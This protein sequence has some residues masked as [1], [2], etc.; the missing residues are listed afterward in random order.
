MCIAS[1]AFDKLKRQEAHRMSLRFLLACDTMPSNPWERERLPAIREALSGWP[2]DI[3]DLF[4]FHSVEKAHHIHRTKS[5][6][7]FF[8][9]RNLHEL[10]RNFYR[11]VSSFGCDI[12]ML[13][14][15]DCYS[16]F[17][18][19][20]TVDQFRKDGIYVVGILGDDEFMFH[21]NRLHVPMFN[22]TVAYV[23]HCVDLYNELVPNS[24]T[25]FPNSCLFPEKDFEKLQVHEDEKTFD[26]VL[27]GA[28]FGNRPDLIRA[29]IRTGVKVALFGSPKWKAYADLEPYYHGFLDSDQIDNTIRKSK[30]VL[31]LLEDHLTGALHMNT[32]VWEAVRMGQMPVA[33]YYPPLIEDYGFTEDED[34]VMYHSEEDLVRKVIHYLA[35]PDD[36]R[37]VAANLFRNT[38]KRFDYRRMYS[39]LFRIIAADCLSAG[40]A[41]RIAADAAEPVITIIDATGGQRTYPGFRVLPVPQ[42]KQGLKSLRARLMNRVSTPYVLFTTGGCR[43]SPYLNTIAALFPDEFLGGKAAFLAAHSRFSDRDRSTADI[44]QIVWERDAFGKYLETPYRTAV[45]AQVDVLK[46]SFANLRLC[47]SEHSRQLTMEEHHESH[48]AN[49]GPGKRIDAHEEERLSDSGKA[50]VVVGLDCGKEHQFHRRSVCVDGRRG[51]G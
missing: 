11:K 7:V 37:R 2:H 14:T 17:L 10:N 22:K 40:R 26:V 16:W 32:K 3:I 19:P 31:A 43:Y 35:D 41:G 23:R 50:H 20:D 27:F 49:D 8:S 38:R 13:G 45:P 9:G 29:L 33:T 4:A 47:T 51:D 39:N 42:G 21:R 36:R 46:Y 5:H 18:F 48:C 12:L 6:A 34:I 44:R 28:P 1:G 30:I 25:W 15:L 24:C